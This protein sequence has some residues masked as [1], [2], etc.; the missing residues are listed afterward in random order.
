VVR[1]GSVGVPASR[2]RDRKAFHGMYAPWKKRKNQPLG[3]S[4]SKSN[5]IIA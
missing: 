1:D 5:R 4:A 3:P 2:A